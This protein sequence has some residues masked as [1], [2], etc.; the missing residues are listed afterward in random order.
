MAKRV[1]QSRFQGMIFLIGIALM[2][3]LIGQLTPSVYAEADPIVIN[4]PLTAADD[5]TDTGTG[6]IF[7]VEPETPA[8]L[9]TMDI[10]ILAI[11]ILT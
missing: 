1:R 11:K 8:G 6:G 2:M 10:V 5:S 4:P 7:Q 3:F 9:T